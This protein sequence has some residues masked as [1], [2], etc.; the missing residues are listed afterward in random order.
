MNFLLIC[1]NAFEKW[2]ISIYFYPICPIT[3]KNYTQEHQTISMELS[4]TINNYIKR[5][6]ENM[7]LVIFSVPLLM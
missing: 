6:T 2:D 5:G 4:T 7:A 3:F 1:P